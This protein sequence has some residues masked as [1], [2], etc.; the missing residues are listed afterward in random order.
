MAAPLNVQAKTQPVKMD[1]PKVHHLMGWQSYGDPKRLEVIRQVA[2][3][4]GRDPRI[5][6]LAVN[7]FRKAGVK[8]RDYK[9]QAAALL[10]WI[11]DPKNV[12]YVN[13]PGER[14]QDPLYTL[15]VKY[16][17]CDDLAILLCSLFESCRLSWKLVI[18]GRDR[19]TGKKTRHIEGEYL[20]R[21]CDWSHIYCMVGTPVFKPAQWY[22]CEP[23]LKVPL[24]W[25]VVSGDASALPEMQQELAKRKPNSRLTRAGIVAAGP[26]KPV[27]MPPPQL[28]PAV[29]FAGAYGANGSAAGAAVASA[30]A[31]QLESEASKAQD[32]AAKDRGEKPPS[33]FALSKLVP[34]ILISVTT[35]VSTSVISQLILES[36]REKKK[37][38][39]EAAKAEA[40]ERQMAERERER[41][42]DALAIMQGDV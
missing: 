8:P 22:F 18:S 2:L 42:L 10:A 38:K 13:E 32:Q 11:Q 15:K 7:I 21:G 29:G 30:V 27:I 39:E 34:A 9:G 17:D 41:Q 24:G 16:G 37:L 12:Y 36:I 4:R 23:T 35:A 25:D 20:P 3:Y 31:T 28:T 5:A 6:T 1:A 33:P 40:Q 26:Q 14:L 19:A